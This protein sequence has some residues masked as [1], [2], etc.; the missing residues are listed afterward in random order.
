M[1]LTSRDNPKIKEAI[2][3]REARVR[4]RLG[5]FLI[6]GLRETTTAIQSGVRIVRLFVPEA[7]AD[8]PELASLCA[9]C[10]EQGEVVVVSDAL[11]T[12]IA[13]GERR[14]VVAVAESPR[15][16]LDAISLPATPLIAVLEQVE[17]PGN[18]G[19]VFR[20]AD[21]AGLDAVI[22]ADPQTD[23]EN[24]AAI[25][26]SQGTLFTVPSGV[27]SRSEVLE[28]LRSRAISMVATRCDATLP[29]SKCDY[30]RP[31]AIILGSEASGLS[32]VWHASDITAIR[33]PMHGRADSLN[34]AAAAAVVFY[35]ARLARSTD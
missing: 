20:S 21:A 31:T 18:V 33:I 28:F 4:R 8:T 2:L 23:L 11:L 32:P 6:D 35:H 19:A 34:I 25:R 16:A 27:A 26:A 22:L 7:A 12:R 3:L 15:R 5:L 1:P 17:K 24:P 30:R 9:R 29:Y 14:S 10:R 13:F